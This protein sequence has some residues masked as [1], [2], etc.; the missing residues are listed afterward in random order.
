MVTS[1]RYDV[2]LL[3]LL[4]QL[5]SCVFYVAVNIV[6]SFYVFDTMIIICHGNMLSLAMS[7]RIQNFSCKHTEEIFISSSRSKEIYAMISSNT[8]SILSFNLCSFFSSADPRDLF[9]GDSILGLS[10]TVAM[11]IF[12]MY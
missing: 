8:F 5:S 12:F 1:E 7:V 6:S 9:S 2:I 11:L 4:L 3:C 10:Y